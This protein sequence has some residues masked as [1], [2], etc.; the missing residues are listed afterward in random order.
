MLGELLRL[1]C[2]L[3]KLPRKSWGKFIKVNKVRNNTKEEG[4]RKHKK[5][6][7]GQGM[8]MA[9]ALPDELEE[10]MKT[11]A[12]EEHTSMHHLLFSRGWQRLA[13]TYLRITHHEKP[14]SPTSSFP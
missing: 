3:S 11:S 6:P 5:R 8:R 2:H 12:R 4:A 10:Q 14:P 1:R 7:Q 9:E 13:M